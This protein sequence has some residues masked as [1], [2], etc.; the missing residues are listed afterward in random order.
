MGR[1]AARSCVHAGR[2]RRDGRARTI[3]GPPLRVRCRLA[4][5]A[6]PAAWLAHAPPATAQS[7]A[8]AAAARD[9]IA[10]AFDA[11]D[12]IVVAERG[13]R[14][15]APDRW[16][17]SP[18]RVLRPSE[19]ERATRELLGA[20]EETPSHSWPDA[21]RSRSTRRRRTTQREKPTEAVRQPAARAPAPAAA[22]E[23]DPTPAA[24]PA[25]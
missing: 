17:S 14:G 11:P 25:P 24:A 10:A 15:R 3:G 18:L 2:A 21:D 4:L 16:E 8:R 22:P 12:R 23:P 1:A 9:P 20:M 13:G 7:D 5:L 19:L 6:L